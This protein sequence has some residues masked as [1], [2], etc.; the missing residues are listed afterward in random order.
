MNFN[1]YYGKFLLFYMII[2]TKFGDIGG[3]IVGISS[4]SIFKKNHKI[5][6]SISPKKS[7]EGT[8]GGLIFSIFAAYIINIY[9]P[10]TKTNQTMFSVI[11]GILFF[12][13]GFCGDLTESVLKRAADIKDSGNI[14]PGIGGAL[15]LIDSLIYNSPFFLLIL[16]I[17]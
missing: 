11:T 2:I 17:I 14:L 10:I 12:T 13:G 9:F 4:I 16:Y 15:D 5:I 1:G 8:I 7:W 3:Y 6:P